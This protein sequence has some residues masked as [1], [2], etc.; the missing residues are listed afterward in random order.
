MCVG[1]RRRT[2]S[3]IADR[4]PSLSRG[5][6]SHAE[7]RLAYDSLPLYESLVTDL[8]AGRIEMTFIG[9]NVVQQHVAAGT[10]QVLATTSSKRSP[11]SVDLPT[12]SEA[13]LPGFAAGTW[14]GVLAPAGTQRAI[15]TRL[16]GEV[17]RA[18]AG[19]D[20]KGLLAK[21]GAEPPAMTPEQFGSFLTTERQKWTRLV[22][23]ANIRIE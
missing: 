11:L 9:I 23:A 7:R 14:Y 5:C 8:L 21:Q 18:L 19:A 13:G 3:R 2:A 12:M 1:R 6:L 15:V 4:P 10:L 17:N 16:N 22:K 20:I